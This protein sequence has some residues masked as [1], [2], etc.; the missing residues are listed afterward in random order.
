MENIKIKSFI[1]CGLFLSTLC[2]TACSPAPTDNYKKV[3]NSG[4]VVEYS[5][6]DSIDPTN[7]TIY[8]NKELDLVM[9]ILSTHISMG[10]NIIKGKYFA[11]DELANVK[12]DL[13]MVAEAISSVEVLNP[14]TDYEDDRAAILRK[15]VNAQDTLNAYCE[16]LE[17]GDLTN[18][19]DCVDLMES[20]YISLSGSFNVQ[21]E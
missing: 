3:D 1:I 14:P 18:L 13:D 21:W 11:A 2:L 12:S 7:Y 19:Q 17:S 5:T 16:V 10:D 9:N 6:Q 15:M 20:E 4:N 8:V